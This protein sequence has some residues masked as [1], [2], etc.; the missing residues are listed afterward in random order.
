MKLILLGAQGSGKGTLA[1]RIVA[2]FDIP[3][4]STGDLLRES[5]AKKE[6]LGLKAQTYMNKGELVPDELVLSILKKRIS[7]ADCKKGFILDG[8]PRTINQAKALEKITDIDLVINL[9]LSKEECIK[10]LVGRRNCRVCG[11][12]DN[13]NSADYT[14]KCRKCGSSL[15]QRDDDK[16]DAIKV[17]LEAYEKQSTPL[18]NFY[19][20]RL[21]KVLSESPDKTYATVKNFLEEKCKN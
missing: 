19:S 6:A 7:K 11:E 8:F 16:L 9:E 2:D 21:V 12:I 3:Q 14:G 17:R 10:R 13:I 5:I 20:D 1:K 4:I 18:I 15:F